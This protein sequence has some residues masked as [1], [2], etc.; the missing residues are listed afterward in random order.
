MEVTIIGNLLFTEP[1]KRKNIAIGWELST[2][3]GKLNLN[4]RILYTMDN[5][6]NDNIQQNNNNNNNPNNYNNNIPENIIIDNNNY[7]NNNNNNIN[8]NNINN[9]NNQGID[10]TPLLANILPVD[11]SQRRIVPENYFAGLE[12]NHTRRR[13]ESRSS[14]LTWERRNLHRLINHRP[15]RTE[16]TFPTEHQI[17]QQERRSMENSQRGLYDRDEVGSDEE[18]SISGETNLCLNIRVNA[19]DY[20]VFRIYNS[21]THQWDSFAYPDPSDER[22]PVES[23]IVLRALYQSFWTNHLVDYT[24]RN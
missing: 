9:N 7:N 18:E 15:R 14:G 8:N 17:S 13:E 12:F 2:S 4:C 5:N 1:V 22:I 6:N 21:T 19:R 20:P 24:P 16:L 11:N 23:R 10:Y 3:Q